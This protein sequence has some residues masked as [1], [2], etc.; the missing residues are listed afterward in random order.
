[1]SRFARGPG[2][3]VAAIKEGKRLED[4][5]VEKTARRRRAKR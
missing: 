1:L 4:F 3:L 5:A 2:W